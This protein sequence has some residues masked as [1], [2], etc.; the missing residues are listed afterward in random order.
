MEQSL[1]KRLETSTA[2]IAAQAAV[3]A[4]SQSEGRRQGRHRDRIDR[5]T[6]SRLSEFLSV[7]FTGLRIIP[8]D[9]PS[10]LASVSTTPM[11]FP[12]GTRNRRR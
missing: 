8:E 1:L 9:G 10:K 5:P 4:P 6:D 3:K 12:N 7:G 11:A 2:S